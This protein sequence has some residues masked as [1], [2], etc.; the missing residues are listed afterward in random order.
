M[1]ARPLRAQS[2]VITQRGVPH[3]DRE[4][5]FH[6]E[7]LPQELFSHLD[8]RHQILLFTDAWSRARDDRL[9]NGIDCSRL[10]GTPPATVSCPGAD[11]V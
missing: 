6:L 3:G 8:L 10:H 4:C 9:R 5:I 2:P 1:E 7:L 11:C